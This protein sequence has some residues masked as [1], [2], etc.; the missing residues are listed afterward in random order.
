[1]NHSSLIKEITPLYNHYKERSLSITGSEALI[2]MWDIGKILSDY[3]KSTKI[4]P[5]KLYR[6][7]YG[8]SENDKNKTRNSWITR[9][10]QGRCYRIFRLFKDKDEINSN[11]PTLKSFTCFREA[12]PFFDNP[13][14]LLKGSEKVELINLL[15]SDESISEIMKIIRKLQKQKIGIINPRT[16]LL[17]SLELEKKVFVDF[18]NYIFSLIKDT[19][20]IKN[21][22]TNLSPEILLLLSK[23][24]LALSQDGLKTNPMDSINV[25][26]QL[27]QQYYDQ[28]KLFAEQKNFVLIRRFRRVIPPERFVKLAD[29]LYT[30]ST[31]VQK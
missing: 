20:I 23:N 4:A 2:T 8:K 27:L 1:M 13:K 6:E 7:V 26:N 21:Y 25:E 29:L 28:I 5:H 31:L 30:L 24:T 17:S 9:E 15:N 12:M 16:Q 19:N 14:Y 10:F 22:D 3:I 11:F 18:Y